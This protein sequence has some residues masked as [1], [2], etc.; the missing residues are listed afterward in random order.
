MTAIAGFIAF[1][2]YQSMY[3]ALS[4]A[5]VIEALSPSANL[6]VV[7]LPKFSKT[8][9]LLEK[10]GE[11]IAIPPNLRNIFAFQEESSSYATSSKK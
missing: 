3:A 5:V 9:A 2:I 8:Q 10:K 11:P 6:Y 4:N 1:F 7:D